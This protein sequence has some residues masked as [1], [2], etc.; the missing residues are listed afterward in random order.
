MEDV[1]NILMK[2]EQSK[3]IYF[4]EKEN[5]KQ[6]IVIVQLGL[7]KERNWLLCLRKV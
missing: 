7:E 4:D 1:K 2:L 5:V 6:Y 3:T